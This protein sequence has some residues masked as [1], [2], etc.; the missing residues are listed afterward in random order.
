LPRSAEFDPRAAFGGDSPADPGLPPPP[1]DATYP[2]TYRMPLW[3]RFLGSLVGCLLAAGGLA[4]AALGTLPVVQS[5][6]GP[7]SPVL[8]LPAA[9][10]M[11][12]GAYLLA[13]V[14]RSKVVLT[15]D[16]IEVHG[17][18]SVRRLARDA[19]AGRRLQWANRQQGWLLCPKDTSAK[20]LRV[21]SSTFRADALYDAWINALPDLDA[22]EARAAEAEIAADPELGATPAERLARLAAGQRL[23]KAFNIAAIALAVWGFFYPYPYAAALLSLAVLPWLT[24]AVVARSAGLYRVGRW[25]NDV[26]P[27]FGPALAAPAVALLLRAL[28]DFGVLDWPRTLLFA[29]L[30]AVVLCSAVMLSDPATRTRPHGALLWFGVA[31]AYGLGTIVLA[32]STL[33]RAPGNEYRVQVLGKH[34]THGRSTS[35]Y[36]TLAPWGPVRQVRSVSVPH[37]LYSETGVGSAVCIHQGPGSLGIPW[38]AIRSC[39]LAPREEG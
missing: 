10:L 38:Y 36:L 3:V 21:A 7:A 20:P 1:P 31:C 4:L 15:A 9:A 39:G 5:P 29:A 28:T 33:D 14:A 30:A 27:V 17:I 11:C 32:D 37:R 19:I 8:L 34:M 22:Q 12:F 16:A 2:R 23:S 35:Y 18:L 13:S 25:R 26:R 6:S 24:I